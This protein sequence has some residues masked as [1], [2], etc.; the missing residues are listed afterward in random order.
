VIEH[1]V[2]VPPEAPEATEVSTADEAPTVDAMVVETPLGRSPLVVRGHT[3]PPRPSRRRRIQRRALLLAPRGE[4]GVPTRASGP[5]ALISEA[6]LGRLHGV[7]AIQAAHRCLDRLSA[8]LAGE[9][10]RLSVEC[11]TLD[12]GWARFHAAVEEKCQSEEAARR[13][14]EQAR[15]DAKEIRTSAAQEA[16]ERLAWVGD[17]EWDFDLREQIYETCEESLYKLQDTIA[18]REREAK[19][20]LLEVEQCEATTAQLELDL[21]HERERQETQE[22]QLEER[23]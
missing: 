3:Q 2:K 16:E 8:S 12:E 15:E 11:S 9:E 4:F 21:Q 10:Q 18:E 23:L 13:R 5:L 22:H 7:D 19:A 17:H 6:P 14:R 1:V 20:K